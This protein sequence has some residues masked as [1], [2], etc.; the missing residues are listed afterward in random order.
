M[1]TL[2]CQIAAR[3]DRFTPTRVGT[4][5]RETLG[6]RACCGSPPHAWGHLRDRDGIDHHCD[7]RFTPTR[8]GTLRRTRSRSADDGSPPHAWGHCLSRDF[9][10]RRYLGS[11]PHA[12][13]HM[14]IPDLMRPIRFTPTRVG[15]LLRQSLRGTT[16]FTPTRVGTLPRPWRS[17][18]R[19]AV[20]PHT[21]GDT[22]ALKPHAC[23]RFT[24]T[25]VGTLN[26]RTCGPPGS[27]PHAWG[28]RQGERST[29]CNR[30]FTPTRVGTL[31]TADENP[32]TS[33]GSPPHAWGHCS[34]RQRS[35]AGL[36]VHPHTRGDTPQGL[37]LAATANPVHPH[38]RGDTALTSA[39]C[40]NGSPPH[41][42]GH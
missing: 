18:R 33:F 30:R 3:L 25:R 26:R 4:L 14:I 20:H 34:G 40:S 1:G 24:P 23:R 2:R 31:S 21:R 22:D 27:P 19:L 32:D 6:D 8:V 28:H 7:C 42:W 37:P 39:P 38:T 12:W 13:G 9:D 11:P 29:T 17:R 41:A 36:T 16:R 15:T 5:P 35:R 10:A